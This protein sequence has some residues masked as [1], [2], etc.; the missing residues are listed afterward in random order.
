MPTRNYEPSETMYP[1][2]FGPYVYT[3]H[4][5]IWQAH[6]SNGW[7]IHIEADT[8]EEAY[9]RAQVIFGG[10]N[11]EYRRLPILTIKKDKLK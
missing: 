10:E 6:K 2:S 4:P 8:A 3:K 7:L 11:F 9:H 5:K 1:D